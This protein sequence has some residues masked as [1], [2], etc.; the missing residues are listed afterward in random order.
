M[1]LRAKALS[2]ARWLSGSMAATTA[3]SL[4]QT[5][6]L[7]RLLEPR[8]FGLTAMIWAFLGFAQMLADAGL[9]TAT[10]QPPSLNRDQLATV[11]WTNMAAGLCLALAAWVATPLLVGYYREPELAGLIPWAAATFIPHAW[12]QQFRA[13][14]QR[15][16]QF[17]RIA[18]ADTM[19]VAAGLAVSVASAG[20][21]AGA[22][23]LVYGGLAMSAVKSLWISA[24]LW[25]HWRPHLHW[26]VGDVDPFLRFGAFQLGDRISNYI[27]NNADYL[28]IGRMLGSQ[29]LGYYRLAFE[30]VIRPL[31]TLNP[32][33]NTIAYPVFA[34]K[35]SDDAALRRGFLEMIRVI[36]FLVA[37]MMAG[38][39]ATAPVAVTA[40]FGP[41]WL[42]AAR[43]LEI[44]S[45]MGLLRALLNPV[46]A[47]NLAKGFPE[48]VFKLNL[49]LA[50]L[51]PAGFWIA[52]P[53]GLQAVCWT[54]LVLLAVV[55]ALSWKPLYQHSVGLRPGDYLRA[56]ST[57][58][59]LSCLMGAA[60]W[61]MR[62]HLADWQ[63]DAARLLLLVSFGAGLYAALAFFF[64]RDF[65]KK[66]L[67]EIGSKLPGTHPRDQARTLH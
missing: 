55:M 33:L 29:A 27:W 32:V 64:D 41:K 42:P 12:G 15:E 21:G 40:I 6:L 19:G 11:H 17:Q 3:L 5:I 38:L 20:Y 46:A 61:G 16:L 56:V 31:A 23:A 49:S 4:L 30:I 45:P 14:A 36:A 13:L 63:T 53:Y 52:V 26:R 35:Q 66:L 50:V 25:H 65:C 67:S 9:S 37:P 10:I 24:G 39:C 48:R 18:V 59:A 60:V 54:A 2:G 47:L 57:P 34:K 22:Y 1:S 58:A 28:L 62:L 8:D 44:L 51:M 43:L 7:S